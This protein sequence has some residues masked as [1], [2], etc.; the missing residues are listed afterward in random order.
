MN[1]TSLNRLGAADVRRLTSA[2][3][4]S[5]STE[6]RAGERSRFALSSFNH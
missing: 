5:S 4:L 1:V 2:F 6:E 3:S